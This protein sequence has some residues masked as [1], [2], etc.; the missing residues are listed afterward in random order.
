MNQRHTSI[1]A[2]LWSNWVTVLRRTYFE[3]PLNNRK[4]SSSADRGC[5][6]SRPE[7]PCEIRCKNEGKRVLSQ[8]H[9]GVR[10]NG[11]DARTVQNYNTGVE[12]ANDPTEVVVI[13]YYILFVFIAVRFRPTAKTRDVN[14][15]FG[16]PTG[17]RRL[18]RLDDR[19]RERELPNHTTNALCLVVVVVVMCALSV[20]LLLCCGQPSANDDNTT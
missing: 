19:L 8:W 5:R 20:I 14:A 16:N 11:A 18:A 13:A 12:I 3:R 4:V 15:I 9:T 1:R 7:K 17:K 2:K 10:L 6:M